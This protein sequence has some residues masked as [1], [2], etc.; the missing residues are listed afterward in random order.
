[1]Q[2]LLFQ[3]IL[4]RSWGL[5]TGD[6]FVCSGLC[7]T[8]FAQVSR[9]GVFQSARGGGVGGGLVRGV[10]AGSGT[11]VGRGEGQGWN[12]SRKLC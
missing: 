7:T 10:C 4:Q 8:I 1:M 9:I 2:R 12:G 5:Q 6:D 3:L 11:I